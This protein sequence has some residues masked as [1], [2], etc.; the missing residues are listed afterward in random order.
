ML[1]RDHHAMFRFDRW[2][3]GGSGRDGKE[4]ECDKGYRRNRPLAELVHDEYASHY[5]LGEKSPT[6][7]MVS[8]AK[9]AISVVTIF[10]IE[11]CRH[12]SESGSL[13]LPCTTADKFGLPT[14]RKYASHLQ[15]FFY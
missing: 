4:S 8:R 6:D 5:Y 1:S 13:C 11:R 14:L 10:L 2:R 9:M 7:D 3:R 15:Y 12:G